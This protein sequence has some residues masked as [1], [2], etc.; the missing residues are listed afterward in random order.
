MQNHKTLLNKIGLLLLLCSSNLQAQT[1]VFKSNLTISGDDLSNFYS[2][3]SSDSTQIYFNSNDYY[4]HAF[5]KKTKKLNWSYY[6][7]NKS[8]TTPILNKNNVFIEQHISQNYDR[9][10]QLDKKNGDTIQTLDINSLQTNPFFKDDVL[11]CAA[12]SPGTGGA[13]LAYDL[14]KNKIIWERFIAHGVSTQ[15]YFLKDKIIANAES[16]NWFEIDYKGILKDTLCKNKAAIFVNDIPCIKNFRYLTHDKK[17]IDEGFLY[18]NLGEIENLKF[19]SNDELTVIMGSEN[20]VLI[21][22]N[23]K[24]KYKINFLDLI[25]SFENESST[26][27]EIFKIEDNYIWFIFKNNLVMY[28]FKTNK[29]EKSFNLSQWNVHQLILESN[30]AIAWIISKNDGQLYAIQLKN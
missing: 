10:I 15:P 25:S 23:K 11:F 19:F 22:N 29:T 8:N 30:N 12:I 2:S 17:E 28:N 1:E 3:I 26:Y 9:C 27:F 24:I 18:K 5:D 16:D 20:L 7:A 21:G 13:I 4:L 6:L 14:K